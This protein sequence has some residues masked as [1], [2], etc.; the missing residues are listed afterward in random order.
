MVDFAAS[1]LSYP[2]SCQQKYIILHH[3]QWRFSPTSDGQI[4]AQIDAAEGHGWQYQ[5]ADECSNKE[6]DAC[7][8]T[9]WMLVFVYMDL[10]DDGASFEIS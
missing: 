9:I 1:K 6:K 2:V 5:Y 7:F 4:E 3:V 10:A 8:Y